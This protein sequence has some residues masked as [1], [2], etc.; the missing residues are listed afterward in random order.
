MS[1]TRLTLI[2]SLVALLISI[3]THLETKALKVQVSASELAPPSATA[4]SASPFGMRPVPST[5][6]GSEGYHMDVS[7]SSD[8][9]S[10]ELKS[11]LP[12]KNI[13][14]SKDGPTGVVNI[15]APMDPESIIIDEQS[16]GTI[17][18]IGPPIN[19]ELP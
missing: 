11:E 12:Q 7:S 8:P 15:G 17:V 5:K 13:S 4:I 3:Y 2:I 1:L 18:D 6:Y 9:S 10:D 16:S 19:P 14:S